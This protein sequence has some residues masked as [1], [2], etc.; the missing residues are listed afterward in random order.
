MNTTEQRPSVSD[1]LVD[2]AGVQIDRLPIL[3]I[4]FDRVA[5]TCS[6]QMRTV[7]ASPCYFS[8]SH[9]EQARI[10]ELLEPYEANAV[11]AILDVPEWDCEVVLGFDRDFIFTIVEVIFGA[12]GNEMPEEDGRAFSSIEMKICTKLAEMVCDVL[13]QSF[14]GEAKATFRLERLETRMHFAVVGRRTAQAAA[15]KFLVQA[16]NRGGEMFIII[17]HGGL[18]MVRRLAK[19]GDDEPSTRDPGWIQQMKTGASRA[20]VGLRAIIDEKTMTLDEVSAMKVGQ[21]IALKTTAR[22]PIKLEA[23]EQP[24]FW[25]Q[26]GQAEGEY[27]LKILNVFDPEEEFLDDIL[28]H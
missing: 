9:V 8:M 19:A 2:A 6:E 25:C 20:E 4:I 3:P 15:A 13:T 24:L 1:R 26:L 5:N 17:P 7:A 22:S 12:D 23:N 11:C 18:Q 10:T 27:R 16:I 21:V 28:A 14:A